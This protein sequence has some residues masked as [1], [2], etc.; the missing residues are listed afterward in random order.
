MELCKPIDCTGCKACANACAKSAITFLADD[1]GFW[2]PKIDNSLCVKCGSC[3]AACPQLQGKHANHANEQ[4]KVYAAWIKNK[5]LRRQSTSGGAF[6]VLAD[7]VLKNKGAVYGAGFDKDHRV[8]HKRICTKRELAQLRGSKYVQSDIGDTFQQVKRDLKAGKTVLFTGSPCQ[9]DGLY[10]LLKSRYEGQLYTVD[11]VCHGVPSPMIYEDYRRY[12]EKT[13]QSK[14]SEIYFRDKTPGWSVFGMKIVFENG[15]V[16]QKDTYNDPY[17]RGFLR[18]LFLRAS[19][20]RCRYADTDRVADITLADFWGYKAENKKGFDDDK[21]I[22]LVMI[23]NANGSQLFKSVSSRLYCMEKSLAE[24]V[25]GNRMLRE[26]FPPAE[27]RDRFWADYPRLS[28]EELAEKYMFPEE[29]PYW[30]IHKRQLIEEHRAGFV[31]KKVKPR[32]ISAAQKVL[33]K[34]IYGKIKSIKDEKDA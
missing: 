21:G 34:K 8:I 2:Y 33:G 26:P 10:A 17:I 31:D 14:I 12:M 27:N 23:N 16:Y 24:A 15:E 7:G 20:H 19:C 32:A 13:Y 5:Q 9:I 29:M 25:A 6:T 1:E 4:Q 18:E 30:Y 22:S 28:F 3:R 11:L